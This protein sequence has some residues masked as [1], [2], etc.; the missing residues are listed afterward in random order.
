MV[1]KKLKQEINIYEKVF[2]AALAF[3]K[4]KA[5]EGYYSFFKFDECWYFGSASNKNIFD[6]GF[7]LTSPML[8]PGTNAGRFFLRQVMFDQNG[9]CKMKRNDPSEYSSL[10]KKNPTTLKQWKKERLLLLSASCSYDTLYK[11]IDNNPYWVLV[12][13]LFSI[14]TNQNLSFTEEHNKI[15]N[16]K[17]RFCVK[18]SQQVVESDNEPANTKDQPVSEYSYKHDG[19]E[20]WRIV[21]KGEE[22]GL[23]KHT[24]GM[25][26]IAILLNEIGK[27]F[28]SKVLVS[29]CK[30]SQEDMVLRIDVD[31]LPTNHPPQAKIGKRELRELWKYKKYLKEQ[32]DEL[33]TSENFD[34]KEKDDVENKLHQLTEHLNKSTRKN[35][36]TGKVES[37]NFKTDA[38]K[39]SEAIYATL[40]T[41]Y[42]NIR[43]EST[44]LASHL[45]KSIA[46]KGNQFSYLPK[47]GQSQISWEVTLK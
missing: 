18:H 46:S 14:L 40:R 31:T 35:V 43:H 39:A 1:I 13:Q 25:G 24:K 26:Y 23:V 34:N 37:V 11:C 27:E 36:N 16:V 17:D 30:H 32:L 7:I 4:E 44:E 2:D 8:P 21:Y 28:N 9:T 33:N 10:F 5:D 15:Q 20:N 12:R 3:T 29:Y 6:D 22:L 19:Q 42:K 47:G 45:K 41:A 38:K